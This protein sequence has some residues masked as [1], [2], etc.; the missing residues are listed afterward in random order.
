MQKTIAELVSDLPEIYQR[1]WNHPEYDES[2]RLCEDRA[3]YIK[4]AIESLQEKLGKK[5]LRV[6][7]LGCAQ[8]YFCFTLR[9]IGCEVSGIDFCEQNIALC[10][11]LSEENGLTCSFR[12]DKLTKD[13]V[14]NLKEGEY[15]VVLCLSVIHHV[16]N[17]NGFEYARSIFEELAGKASVVFT[18][19]A[20]KAEPLY[21]NKNLPAA[22]DDWFQNIAFFDE[23]AFFPT[24]LSDIVRPLILFS[25]K[26]F[27][28]ENMFFSF[29]EWKK[30]SYDLKAKDDSRRYYFDDSHLMKLCR[31]ENEYL[32]I[33]IRNEVNFLKSNNDLSFIP[34]VF[35]SQTTSKSDLAVYK[36]NKG[37]LL[38]DEL[39][40]E[41]SL[42]FDKI[43][44]DILGECVELEEKGFYHG[45]LRAWNICVKDGSAFLIDFGN[46]QKETTDTVAGFMN[47]KMTFSVFDAFM[48]FCYDILLGR[49]YELIRDYGVYDIAAFYD[50]ERLDKKHSAFF[51]S[52]LLLENS[53][54]SFKRLKYIFDRIITKEQIPEFSDSEKLRILEKQLIRCHAVTADYISLKKAEAD[55]QRTK[56]ALQ[57][58]VSALQ[59]LLA[60]QTEIISRHESENAAKF[61]QL[62][63]Q[64]E[65]SVAKISAI[66]AHLAAQNETIASQLQE[67][68][69]QSQQLSAQEQKIS[70]LENRLKQTYN[71]LI[72]TRHR[73]L[74]GAAAW[75][76]RKV[77]RR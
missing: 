65:S 15:D 42:D 35:A 3:G 71:L 69:S 12:H 36:I 67:L 75:L 57:N 5:N 46:I 72:N 2:S 10:K 51:K 7:D 9:S 29:D 76:F 13:F 37:T 66:E 63:S 25:D 39:K 18:E 4:K 52:Y 70:D 33:E 34:K 11:A 27:Y 74:Y 64:I 44:S 62:K 26:Y 47:P 16:A 68:A 6:L 19:L 73:T 45:D 48:M 77:F 58:E 56:D 60:E 30:S 54:I 38:L 41:K 8:G 1:I 21:W 59:K 61:S 50:F 20:V 43:F 40:S 24:H 28:C 14:E 17:E 23:L 55:L 53:E 32:R 49:N 31:S 22:Y